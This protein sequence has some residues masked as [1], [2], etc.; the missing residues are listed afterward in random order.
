MIY[1]FIEMLYFMY[2]EGYAEQIEKFADLLLYED[3]IDL[4][5]NDLFISWAHYI[6]KSDYF[7]TTL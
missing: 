1:K 4:S 5:Q 6:Q 7:E 3:G 2:G